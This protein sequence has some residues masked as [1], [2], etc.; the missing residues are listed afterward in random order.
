MQYL[1]EFI[2]EN[3]A[4]DLEW[5]LGVLVIQAPP[6]VPKNL[7]RYE[8]LLSKEWRDRV[9]PTFMESTLHAANCLSVSSAKSAIKNLDRAQR[10]VWPAMSVIEANLLPFLSISPKQL[11]N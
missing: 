7:N 8:G 4:S 11:L 9:T 6:S 10:K 3:M 2:P 5:Q 1:R